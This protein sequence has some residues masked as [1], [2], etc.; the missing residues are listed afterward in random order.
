MSSAIDF[1]RFLPV[2]QKIVITV[3]IKDDDDDDSGDSFP[4]YVKDNDSDDQQLFFF[5]LADSHAAEITPLL[6]TGM[7]IAISANNFQNGQLI[8]YGKIT[9]IQ[10][11]GIIGCWV[12]ISTQH[13]ASVTQ[14]RSHVRISLSCP[15]AVKTSVGSI[16]NGAIDNLSAGGARFASAQQFN[17]GDLLTLSF[18]L[19]GIALNL[20]AQVIRSYEKPG[21]FATLYDRFSTSVF[22]AG[23]TAVQEQQLM[24]ACFQ[25]QLKRQSGSD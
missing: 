1:N 17:A 21:R 5:D 16:L 14:R 2:G 3:W 11:S 9:S 25:Q 6:Y 15:V 22:F 18:I 13:E 24:K 12:K 20:T 7:T 23:L 8:A 4:S 10:Q 19:D